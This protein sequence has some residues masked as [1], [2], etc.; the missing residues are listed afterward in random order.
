MRFIERFS[1]HSQGGANPL[2]RHSLPDVHFRSTREMLDDF[3]WLGAEKAQK[4]VVT[5]SNLIADL[6]DDDITP[7]KDKLYTPEAPGWKKA[8]T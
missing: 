5:N 7:V 3:S 8:Q 2:N 1:F 6:I 4:L